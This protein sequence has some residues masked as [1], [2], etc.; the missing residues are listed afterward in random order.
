MTCTSDRS[1]MASSG[2]FR[3]AYAP[4]RT[5]ASVPSRTINL[6]LSEKSMMVLSISRSDVLT[7]LTLPPLRLC[8]LAMR[9]RARG[10]ELHLAFGA[11]ARLVR[12]HVMGCHEAGVENRQRST[13]QRSHA[14]T[15]HNRDQRHAA[16]G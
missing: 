11:L 16:L 3:T 6:F 8:R 14:R 2:M 12:H 10:Y 1:G 7:L 9:H 4:L 13:L 5:R 15:L